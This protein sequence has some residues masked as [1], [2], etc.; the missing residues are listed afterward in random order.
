ME[1]LNPHGVLRGFPRGLPRDFFL[2]V[3][4]E[5]DHYDLKIMSLLLHIGMILISVQFLRLFFT[6]Y[7]LYITNYPDSF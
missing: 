5:T 1:F 6:V 2:L 4:P 7:K 3:N